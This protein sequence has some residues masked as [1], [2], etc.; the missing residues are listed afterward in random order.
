MKKFS[1]I[2]LRKLVPQKYRHTLWKK[3]TTLRYFGL[4]Y[5][6][7]F[8][9]S[10]L[11][12]FKPSGL[13]YSV[14]KEKEVVGG[15]Y[16]DSVLCPVCDSQ[17]RERLVYLYLL[18]RTEIFIN[19]GKLLHVAPEIRLENIFKSNPKLDYLTA[20]INPEGVMVQMDITRINYPECTFDYIICNHVL[21]HIEDD[22]QAISELYRVLKP[23]GWAIL[24]VP[25]SL[26]LKRTYEDF[27]I[28]TEFERRKAYGQADHVR[29]YARDYKD[30]LT[31][32]GFDVKIFSW[33]TDPKNF[34][35]LQ[36]KFGLNTQE[37]V[38]FAEKKSG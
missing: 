32:A 6:C 26:S 33:I 38:Y 24:Q 31:Q 22:A 27:S 7:P 37:K 14:L 16:R 11:R 9:D 23:D 36:N 1:K 28:K 2:L 30:R 5:R 25:I 12:T 34:G 15:G 8:C 18:N 10:K 20:D 21:E 19:P 29:I 35:G 4:N 13:T 17:D 3:Y